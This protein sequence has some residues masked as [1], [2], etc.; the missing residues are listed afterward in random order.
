MKRTLISLALMFQLVIFPPVSWAENSVSNV[1]VAELP[2]VG[3]SSVS[4]LGSPGAVPDDVTLLAPKIT[5]SVVTILCGNKQGTA[6]SINTELTAQQKSQ[7]FKSYLVTNHH[8]VEDC[9]QSKTVTLILSDKSR[10]Q[11]SVY[12]WDETTDLAGILTTTAVPALNWQGSLPLQGYWVGVL[13]SPLGF[14][15]ILTTGIVSSVDN[16]TLVGT[17]TAP[18]NP[19]NSGG[20]VFDRSGRVIGIATAKYINAEGF[21]I[22]NGTPLLC[23]AIVNCPSG[24]N[25]WYGQTRG[26]GIFA[27]NPYLLNQNAVVF[28]QLN[29]AT[30]TGILYCYTSP[31]LTDEMIDSGK[32]TGTYW[33]ITD[34]TSATVLDS[35]LQPIQKSSSDFTDTEKSS[36][37]AKQSLK[38][39]AGLRFYA[40]TV[41]NQVKG[42][43][44]ECAISIVAKGTIGEFTTAVRTAQVS[45]NNYN[46]VA[47]IKPTPTPTPTVEAKKTQSIQ[48]WN[49]KSE[50]SLALQRAAFVI[51]ATSGLPVSVASNTQEFCLASGREVIPIKVGRCV[52]TASQSGNSEYLAAENRIL[53]LD[54]V[55]GKK[56]TIT[57]TKGKLVKKVTGIKPVCPSGYK[58]KK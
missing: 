30:N 4:T 43:E 24:S 3:I 51:N 33:R 16:E 48:N 19:G 57:C 41:S 1:P 9:T 29:L 5:K 37:G 18:I 36:N 46:T 2:S 32:I 10:Q 7:G 12:T 21:G 52:L 34:I 44:Y 8:V 50:L 26:T 38:T 25:V 6:W 35:Y 11:G 17:L 22:F 53:V 13:G 15:G 42:H 55:L 27:T 56:V 49:L 40:Y 58:V 47:E 31:S 28:S 14:A 20:P 54:V 39:S 45:G 23:K